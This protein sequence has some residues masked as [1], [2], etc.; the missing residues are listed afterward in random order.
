MWDQ[1][2]D[3]GK[4]TYFYSRKSLYFVREGGLPERLSLMSSYFVP[5]K[6]KRCV[7]LSAFY[8][9]PRRKTKGL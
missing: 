8:V 7:N 4:L 2:S 6:D 3:R 1:R 5:V 9:P